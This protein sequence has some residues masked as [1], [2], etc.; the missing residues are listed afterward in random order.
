[1]V[2]NVSQ[3][4]RQK[5]NCKE[6]TCGYKYFFSLFLIWA[7]RPVI[8]PQFFICGCLFQIIKLFLYNNGGYIE[9]KNKY[10][11]TEVPEWE[12]LLQK[13]QPS[14]KQL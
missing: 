11:K 3:P 9:P 6:S 5:E 12:Q 13:D 10:Q 7:L 4:N 2:K 8:W 14:S 1:M